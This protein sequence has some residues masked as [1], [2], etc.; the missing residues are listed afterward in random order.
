MK[1][2]QHIIKNKKNLDIRWEIIRAIRDFFW[3]EEFFDVETPNMLRLP[4]Q[5]P[6]LDPIKTIIHNER[7][8][9]FQAY[10]H[11]SPEYTMKKMLAAGYE[12]IFSITKCYRDYESFGGYHHPEFTMLEWYRVEENYTKIMDDIEKLFLYISNRI[13]SNIDTTFL[14]ISMRDLWE[15][16][17][18]IS[19]D[20]CLSADEL[21]HVS[22]QKGYNPSDDERYED[23]FF[24][25][26]L[27]EIEP[28]LA[29]LGNVIVFDYPAQ[30][31]SLS[32]LSKRDNRYAERFEVY[33]H[34]IEIANAFSELTDE[35]EQKKRLEEEKCLRVSLRK[36]IFDIDDE[37]L[38]AV[39]IMPD[40]AGIA[41]GVDRLVQ[42]FIGCKN[43][44][45]VLP[46]SIEK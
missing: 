25:I 35:V 30:L 43:I 11:T 12:K 28:K 46:L 1:H 16:Y 33:I 42:V 2:V 29:T 6:Y 21:F 18:G 27:N 24:R 34:G 8:E 37:F 19:L 45:D 10:F 4:G 15:K 26:F 41:L 7:G 5:E 13:G 9:K 40:S 3:Q 36:D 23:L 31:A 20:L 32:R 39:G 17:V 22:K 14:R 44:N 38:A